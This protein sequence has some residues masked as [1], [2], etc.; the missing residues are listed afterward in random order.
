MRCSCGR[1][2]RPYLTKVGVVWYCRACDVAP[3]PTGV[4][5]G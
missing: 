1:I 2:R 3:P 4:R 5:R